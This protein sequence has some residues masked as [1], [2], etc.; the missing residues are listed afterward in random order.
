MAFHMNKYIK[1]EEKDIQLLH[2]LCKS[3]RDAALLKLQKN[4]RDA[5]KPV[6]YQCCT[7]LIDVMICRDHSDCGRGGCRQ[8]EGTKGSGHWQFYDNEQVWTD[9][10]NRLLPNVTCFIC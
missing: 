3:E 6:F 7:H 10:M 2:R 9:T 4:N 5:S 1:N 8:Y